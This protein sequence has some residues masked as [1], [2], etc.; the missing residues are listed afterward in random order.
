MAEATGYDQWKEYAL[1][2]TFW[3]GMPS[4]KEQFISDLYNTSSFMS[5]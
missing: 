2:W 5:A 3:S 1:G 4:G